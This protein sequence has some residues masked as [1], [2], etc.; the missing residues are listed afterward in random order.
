MVGCLCFIVKYSFL[1]KCVV[2]ILEVIVKVYYIVN[3]GCFGLVVVDLLKDI[4]NVVEEYLYEF[5][6]DV[7]MCFYNLIEKGYFK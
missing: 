6:I 3:I 5:L 2:D 7:I 4:V 1:V